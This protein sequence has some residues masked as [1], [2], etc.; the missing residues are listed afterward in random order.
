MFELKSFLK[1]ALLAV[2]LGLLSLGALGTPAQAQLAS[3]PNDPLYVNMEQWSLGVYHVPAAFARASGKNIKVAIFSYKIDANHNDLRGKVTKIGNQNYDHGYITATNMALL[4]AGKANNGMGGTGIAPDA[5]IL[6]VQVYDQTGVRNVDSIVNG[7]E[8]ARQAGAKILVFDFERIFRSEFPN[9]TDLQRINN[10]LRA[11][12]DQHNGLVFIG[13]GDSNITDSGQQRFNHINVI[14]GWNRMY[15]TGSSVRGPAVTFSCNKTGPGW[16]NSNPNTP[17][18][19]STRHAAAEAAGVAALVWSYNPSVPNTEVERILYETCTR[20]SNHDRNDHYGYGFPNADLAIQ[21]M[22]A[23]Q[24][25]GNPKIRTLRDFLGREDAEL[26][27]VP[28]PR[29]G[30][31][32]F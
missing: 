9:Y 22:P 14:S 18:P 32:G 24:K 13:S 1:K 6:D 10:A 31:I 20:T 12:H 11:F 4:I 27:I 21:R 15:Q 7:I 2:S 26:H 19:N 16:A 5:E 23:P 25:F 17:S 28:G 3:Q 30:P 8:L 29:V